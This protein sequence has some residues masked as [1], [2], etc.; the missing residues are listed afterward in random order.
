MLCGDCEKKWNDAGAGAGV[1]AGANK[2]RT[3]CLIFFRP[4]LD[5]IRKLATS[6]V[7]ELMRISSISS[8]SWFILHLLTA[9][10]TCR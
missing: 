9:S 4:L 8:L 3:T 5:A 6:F 2:D 1:G 7:I 10:M